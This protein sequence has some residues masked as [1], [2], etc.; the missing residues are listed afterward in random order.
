MC[1]WPMAAATASAL[2][3]MDKLPA[4]ACRSVKRFGRASLASMDSHCPHA[5]LSVSD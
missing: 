3:W 5:R 2:L 1:W 4:S